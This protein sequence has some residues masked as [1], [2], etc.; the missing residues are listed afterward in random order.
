MKVL[1]KVHSKLQR[2]PWGSQGGPME[3]RQRER[4]R[5]N[6]GRMPLL[7]PID[8]VLWGSWAKSTLVI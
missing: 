3:G 7:E 5:M 6:L 2:A 4:E 8:G 1:D